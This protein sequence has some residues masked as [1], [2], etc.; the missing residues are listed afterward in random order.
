MKAKKASLPL[1]FSV[2]FMDM[3]GFGF[4]IPLIPDYI[5]NFGGAPA[6]AG[7]LMASYALGQFF[8]APIVG[9]LSDRYGR[10]PLLLFSIGGTFL[11]LLLLG[12]ARSLP[13]IFASRILDGL[14]GGNITVAQSYIVDITDDKNRAKGFGIIGMAFG[15]GFIIG[16]VF[17]GLLSGFGLSAPAFVA[18]GIAAVNLALIAFALPESLSSDRKDDLTRN[19]RRAFSAA[20]LLET[21]RRKGTGT[22]LQMSMVYSFAFT[23]FESMFAL[24]AAEAL[25]VGPSERGWL[26][27]YVGVL[28][29]L[30]QGGGVGLLAKRFDERKLAAVSISVAAVSLALYSLS[31]SVPT[32]MLALAPLSLGSGVASTMLRTLLTKSVSKESSGGTLGLAASI[33]SVNRILAPLA[34]GAILASIGPRAPGLIAAALAGATALYAWKRLVRED[35]LSTDAATGSCEE[36]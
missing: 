6:L 35:C 31:P 7:L 30:V 4:I 5:H 34:G 21:L 11:S 8:A 25:G 23:L 20:L 15:F 14:T 16:P 29:A 26:L 2:V 12:F 33:D 36:A 22:V 24:F 32:L 17:G 3:V 27:A 9:R 18:A 28:V 1:L 13:L 19:P 10:K